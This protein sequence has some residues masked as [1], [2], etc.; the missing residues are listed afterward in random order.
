MIEWQKWQQARLLRHRAR[1]ERHEGSLR[2]GMAEGL[3]IFIGYFPVA[4]A[5]GLLAKSVPLSFLEAGLFSAIV[6]AGA[7]QFIA[8]SLL[9]SGIGIGSIIVTTFLINSRHLLMS[10]SVAAKLTGTRRWFP[11]A[12]FGVTDETFAVAT[13]RSEPFGT[14]YLLALN[15]T[16]WLGWLTGTLTGYLAGSLLPPRLQTAMGILLYVMFLGILMPEVR[17]DVRVLVLAGLSGVI[18]WGLKATGWLPGGWCLVIAIL[19]SVAIV[20]GINSRKAMERGSDRNEATGPD[21]EPAEPEPAGGER[22]RN[23]LGD[24]SPTDQKEEP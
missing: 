12:A 7:S 18:H 16:A 9:A 19:V 14:P 21:M 20:E 6:F 4:V 13:T 24:Q 22:E 23:D 10:T 1:L 2:S 8:A 15:T 5:F 3:P 17:K 11:L